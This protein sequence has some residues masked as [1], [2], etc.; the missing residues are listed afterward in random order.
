MTSSLQSD[1]LTL[2]PEIAQPL[3]PEQAGSNVSSAHTVGEESK[4]RWTVQR[5]G[6]SAAWL[7]I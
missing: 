2:L 6:P 5:P 3:P 4:T 1:T 7:W